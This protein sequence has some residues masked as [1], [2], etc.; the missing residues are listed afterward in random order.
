MAIEWQ[1]RYKVGD[2]EIDAQHQ[3][4]FSRVNT[5]LAAT[6]KTGM[7]LA[8]KNLADCVREHFLY[9]EAVMRSMAYPELNAHVR[10]HR[11]LMS[12]LNAV[13]QLIADYSFEMPNFEAFLS[14][15][16]INHMQ[17]LDAQLAVYVKAA[18][19]KKK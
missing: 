14:A 2:A 8:A 16:L 6:G 3:E 17:T 9:E 5:L 19:K 12:K 18:K 1:D 7:T 15:W 10:Q 11:T 13:A 4:M